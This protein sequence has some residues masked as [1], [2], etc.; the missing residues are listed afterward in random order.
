M[1][2]II[3]HVRGLE[4]QEYINTVIDGDKRLRW[5]TMSSVGDADEMVIEEDGTV[6]M[7]THSAPWVKKQWQYTSIFHPL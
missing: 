6:S 3:E 5:K 2:H 7:T 4:A 1:E